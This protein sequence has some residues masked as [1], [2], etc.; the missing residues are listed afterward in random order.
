MVSVIPFE[1]KDQFVNKQFIVE[2]SAPAGL[3]RIAGVNNIIPV[4]G[5]T[6]QTIDFDGDFALFNDI[7]S[8]TASAEENSK[9]LT[10]TASNNSITFMPL[11]QYYG[12][13]IPRRFLEITTGGAYGQRFTTGQWLNANSPQSAWAALKRNPD[14]MPYLD[15]L[16]NDVNDG[17][18]RE[19]GRAH[20]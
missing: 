1:K 17:I 7:E 10:S 9:K 20:V 19:I 6:W 13:R 14:L 12:Q 2:H 11:T 18:G 15:A 4:Q 16:Q 5:E 8:T 3:V